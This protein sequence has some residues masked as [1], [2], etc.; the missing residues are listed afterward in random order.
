MTPRPRANLADVPAYV[1]GRA[2]AADAF[3]LSSNE[4]AFDPLP[5]VLDAAVAAVVR[6]N[7]YPDMGSQELYGALAEFCGVDQENLALG[8]GS[9][10]LLYGAIL[11]FCEPGDEVVH[12][13]RSFEA[14]PIACAVGAARSVPVALTPDGRHDLS[15]MAE[16]ITDRTRIVMVCTPNNPTGPAVSHAEVEQFLARIPG[17]VLVILDEAY[18][19]FVRMS[20]PLD[21]MAILQG[22]DNVAVCRTF[23]KAHGL[24]GL[25]VGYAVASAEVARALRLVTLPFGVSAP[26]QA[27]AVASLAA[28]DAMA[29]RVDQ[30]VAERARVANGLREAGWDIP[31][32]QGNFV[33][34][35]RAGPDVVAAA[36]GA[37]VVVRPL[38]VGDP[39]G[40]VR[41]TI[42][43]PEGNDR[44]LTAL[45]L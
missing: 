6:M 44:V 23:S 34:L 32:P 17:H 37:G 39:T 18:Y 15:A 42:G 5:G 4:L 11:A 21:A 3:K 31:D 22:R 7:R 29:E 41:I 40:G 33:W 27:A 8:T 26:A 25:R 13:H 36:T 14:Y 35:P 1:P 16:A 28:T 12:A 10:G 9:V 43:E 38:G 2:A 20:D 45:A 24:A 30:V 19:E